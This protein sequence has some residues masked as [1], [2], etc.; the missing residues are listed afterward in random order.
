MAT[1]SYSLVDEFSLASS[2]NGRIGEV[3][4]PTISAGCTAAEHGMALARGL[5]VFR[6]RRSMGVD[7]R[8]AIAPSTS[9]VTD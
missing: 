8:H 2:A 4:S 6:R 3:T 1:S 5:P 7:D 9:F